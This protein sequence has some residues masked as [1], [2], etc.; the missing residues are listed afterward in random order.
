M[1]TGRQPPASKLWMRDGIGTQADATAAVI[2]GNGWREPAGMADGPAGRLLIPG[3]Q[4]LLLHVIDPNFGKPD[5]RSRT[6]RSGVGHHFSFQHVHP[7]AARMGMPR[8]DDSRGIATSE[9]F[10]RIPGHFHQPQTTSPFPRGRQILSKSF[11]GTIF[12]FKIGNPLV[13]RNT[14]SGFLP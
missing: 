10:S 13:A 5:E 1:T 14:R 6:E 3:F 7:V 12:L 8:I 11:L 9:L 4:S 2:E